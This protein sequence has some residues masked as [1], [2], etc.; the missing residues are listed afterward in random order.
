MKQLSLSV[1]ALLV[2][3]GFNSQAQVEKY[4]ETLKEDD[5]K[6]HLTYISSHGLKGSKKS[7]TVH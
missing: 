6:R 1:F 2:L 7:G 4:A 5:L 3:N